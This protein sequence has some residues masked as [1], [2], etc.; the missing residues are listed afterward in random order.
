MGAAGGYGRRYRCLVCPYGDGTLVLVS[1][2]K[3]QYFI[4]ALAGESGVDLWNGSIPWGKGKA[5]H[6]SHL[7]RP[8]IVGQRL[9]VR[10]GVFELKSGNALP[11]QVPVGGCGTYAATRKAFF[12]AGSGQNSAMWDQE[13]GEYTMWNRLRPTAG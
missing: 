3:R 4:Y 5:D 13:S 7:S 12:F 10:P 2:T 11:L 8:A 1:S 9:Y 6:G